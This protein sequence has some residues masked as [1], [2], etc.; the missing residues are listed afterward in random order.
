[1][2]FKKSGL[3]NVTDKLSRFEH[4]KLCVVNGD[5]L[6]IAKNGLA[7]SISQNG[8]VTGTRIASRSPVNCEFDFKPTKS[9]ER[10]ACNGVPD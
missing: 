2:I 7:F 10:F 6:V 8:A 3:E 5:Y 4:Q 9:D 1:M